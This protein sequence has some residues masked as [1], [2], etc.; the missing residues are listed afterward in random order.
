[1]TEVPDAAAVA[2]PAETPHRSP[3]ADL[4]GGVAWMGLAVA[5]LVASIRMDR[6]ADQDI[7]PYTIPGLLPGLLSILM[8]FFGSMLALRG[9]L[10][11]GLRQRFAA[12]GREAIAPG[13]TLLVIGLCAA[14]DVGL[15]GRGLPFWAAA[16]IF[17][18]VAVL[19]LER[20]GEGRIGRRPT[21]AAMLKAAVIGLATGGAVTALFQ[22]VFLVHLP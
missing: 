14:F 22:E 3:H 10:A 13:R 12:A 18:T 7:N 1:M 8:L 6:L 19:A 21:P 16:A 17:V 5:I 11:G 15:V 20:S 2:P 9:L 4:W